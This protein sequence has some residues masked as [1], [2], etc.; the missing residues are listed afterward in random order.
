MLLD[1]MS[2]FKNSSQVKQECFD[3]ADKNWTFRYHLG[4]IPT[5]RRQAICD[6]TVDAF[7]RHVGGKKVLVRKELDPVIKKDA[8]RQL[9]GFLP[10]WLL[11]L[12]LETLLSMLLQWLWDYFTKEHEVGELDA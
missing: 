12:L 8:V 2:A 11:A 7:D 10:Q 4:Y 3:W 6:A 9:K 1:T 5:R